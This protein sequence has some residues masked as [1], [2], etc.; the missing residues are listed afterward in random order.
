[1]STTV[2]IAFP[3][4]RYHGTPWGRHVNEGAI[5]FPPSPWRLLRA[6][7]A[8]WKCRAPELNDDA[9][10]RLLNHLAIAPTYGIP[11]YLEAHTRHYMPDIANG[12]DKVIDA[13]AVLERNAELTITWPVDLDEAQ[14]RALT[15]LV[16]RLPYIGRAESVCD[17]RVGSARD[18]SIART[19]IAPMADDVVAEDVLRLLVPDRPLDIAA[20][21]A[22]TTDIRKARRLLPSGATWQ[23]Y[24]APQPAT[25]TL[26]VKRPLR[27]RPTAVRW[28]FAS[29][30]RP[31][32]NATVAMTDVFRRACMGAFG[33]R[34]NNGVSA[35]LSGKSA[36]GTPLRGHDHAHYLAL[37]ADGDRLIDTLLLWVPSGIGEDEMDTLAGLRRLTGFEHV[38]DF[39]PGQV[40]LES[41]GTIAQVAPELVG[42]SAVWQSTTPFAPARFVP[43]K[44]AWEDHVPR[45]VAQELAWRSLPVP[46][47]VDLLQ[48]PWLEF[49]RHRPSKER[50]GSARRA[51][52]V[53]LEFDELI[54]GPLVL[55]ALSHFGL[56]LFLPKA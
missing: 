2:A 22:R 50:I 35:E 33:R 45:E 29:A 16:E 7:Y 51:N 40:G 23:R 20:L 37:D 52:G 30:A 41:V 55:G 18:D 15:V 56:G 10:H 54:T 32:V 24:N 11:E 49:R 44:Q 36:D 19:L 34:N 31:S 21:A 12:T 13:F 43:R 14:L 1:M 9:V 46:T 8:T 25:P 5:E 53:R 28:T 17:A 6:L 48:G 42:P 27:A 4:G 47:R 26:S 3:W 38:A 39:R